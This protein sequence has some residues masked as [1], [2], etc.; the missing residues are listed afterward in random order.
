MDVDAVVAL[1]SHV[2]VLDDDIAARILEVEGVCGSGH[3]DVIRILGIESD[4][5]TFDA[6]VVGVLA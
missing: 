6:D 2:A 5:H 3:T 4:S 1:V